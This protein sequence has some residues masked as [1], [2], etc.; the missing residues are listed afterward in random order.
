[1]TAN[2]FI[3][4]VAPIAVQ[5]RREG[6]PIFPSVR[7]AQAANETGW[8]LHPWNNLVGFKVGSGQTNAYWKGA[9]V[10]KGTWE[11]YDGTRTDVTAAFRAYDCIAD[12]FRDQDLLFTG[13]DNYEPICAAKTPEE[14]CYAFTQTTYKYATDPA[15][16]AKLQRMI[17]QY[18]LKQFDEVAKPM[19]NPDVANT[20][21]KTWMS[22]SWH[23]AETE[24]VRA[25]TAGRQDAA[26]EWQKQRD[27][28]HWLAN[29]L[30]KASG[31]P[32]E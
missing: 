11:V 2:D 25:A 28:V 18:G 1:M 4:V 12:C 19:L 15:Y 14:Q 32:E 27:Y 21:I 31:Q 30:R 17:E 26:E 6:S 22:P 3:A 23:D 9:Y 8:T 10:N 5:L 7:I 16:S 24:R 13:W 29:E 20:I